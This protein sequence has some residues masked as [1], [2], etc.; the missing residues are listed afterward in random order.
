V[1]AGVY[2][3]YSFLLLV[4]KKSRELGRVPALLSF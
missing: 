4:R 3:R 1:Q 2:Y